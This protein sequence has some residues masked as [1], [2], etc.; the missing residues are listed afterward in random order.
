[1]A[2]SLS[3]FGSKLKG[4]GVGLMHRSVRCLP[5]WLALNILF[6]WFARSRTAC[7]TSFL[8]HD[9]KSI[10]AFT[11]LKYPEAELDGALGKDSRFNRRP[12]SQASVSA[13]IAAQRC[14][15]QLEVF[16]I[17]EVWRKETTWPNWRG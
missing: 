12:P 13:T 14:E 16:R 17:L 4:W 3:S 1:M 5:S 2:S 15:N 11:L 6:V 8:S 7:V 10:R 9:P